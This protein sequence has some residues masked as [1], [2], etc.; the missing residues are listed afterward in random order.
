MHSVVSRSR[1]NDDI[2]AY[3]SSSR[4]PL[5]LNSG[6][7]STSEMKNIQL[8][9]GGSDIEKGVISD[10]GEGGSLD[11]SWGDNNLEVRESDLEDEMAELKLRYAERKYLLEAALNSREGVWSPEGE[12]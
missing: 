12:G 8:D 3:A 5:T 6:D 4:A 1:S 9:R 2:H 10:V 11:E 7:D